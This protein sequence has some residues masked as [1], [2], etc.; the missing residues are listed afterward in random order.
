MLTEEVIDADV[1]YSSKK[2]DN[3]PLWGEWVWNSIQSHMFMGRDESYALLETSQL[4]IY[5]V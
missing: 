1:K 4:G 3:T 2:I 5:K